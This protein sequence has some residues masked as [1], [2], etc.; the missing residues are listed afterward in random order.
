MRLKQLRFLQS[1]NSLLTMH[2]KMNSRTR[3]CIFILLLSLLINSTISQGGNELC[4]DADCTCD[5][6]GDTDLIDVIC[7]CSPKK[8][9]NLEEKI[10]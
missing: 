6:S 10:I 3:L 9:N 1:E 7:K 8:V 2:C 5:P 4:S